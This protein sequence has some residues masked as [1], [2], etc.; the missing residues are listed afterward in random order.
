MNVAIVGSRDYT[1]LDIVERIVFGIAAKYPDA[2]IVSGGARGVDQAA[3][4]AA[5]EGG[6]R[7]KS[8]RP[9][10]SPRSGEYG[11]SIW[12]SHDDGD[13]FGS[14]HERFDSYGK[15]AF[16]RNELIVN[17]ADVVVAFWD[18]KSR[19]TKHDIELARAAGKRLFIYNSEGK[20]A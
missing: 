11:I 13:P 4:R 1:R 18:G 3:E 14:V 6:L 9:F 15:A 12:L 20:L 8:Y 16:F 5:Q 7:V 2:W 10:E 17:D 19:G